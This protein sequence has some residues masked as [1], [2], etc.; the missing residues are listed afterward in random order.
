MTRK[1]QIVYSDD[2]NFSIDKKFKRL[3]EYEQDNRNL[4]KQE[5]NNGLISEKEMDEKITKEIKKLNEIEQK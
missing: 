1:L 2:F 5:F 3:F 4:I